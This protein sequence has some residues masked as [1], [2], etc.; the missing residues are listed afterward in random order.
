MDPA[1]YLSEM[2]RTSTQ[3]YALGRQRTVYQMS[4]ALQVG[5]GIVYQ[6]SRGLQFARGGTYAIFCFCLLTTLPVD[7]VAMRLPFS[8]RCR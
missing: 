1:D 4:R 3:R 5:S 8:A 7:S 6:T 2:L